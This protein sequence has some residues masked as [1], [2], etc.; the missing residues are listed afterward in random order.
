MSSKPKIHSAMSH[1]D[2]KRKSHQRTATAGEQPSGPSKAGL[3]NWIL[4]VE[5]RL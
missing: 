2:Q 4:V 3:E 1:S 5:K